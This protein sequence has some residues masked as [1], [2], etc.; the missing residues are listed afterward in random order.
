MDY[1]VVGKW[2]REKR[3]MRP[4]QYGK[5]RVIFLDSCTDHAITD[6][7]KDALRYI[8]TTIRFFHKNETGMCQATDYFIINKMKKAWRS[9]WDKKLM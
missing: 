2:L 1:R 7:V 5:Q 4:L 9:R 8:N 3:V 6:E